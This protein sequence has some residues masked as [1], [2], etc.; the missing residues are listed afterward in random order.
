[1]KSSFI[2]LI[3]F[4]FS[5]ISTANAEVFT[6][7]EG[8]KFEVMLKPQKTLI[9]L[10]EPIFIDFDVKNLS[11]VDLGVLWGGDYRN[12]FGR[13]ESFDV[14][15]FDADSQLV[16]KP[17]TM[18]FGGLSTFQKSPVGKSYNFRLYLPHWATIESIG[19]Y[20]IQID[21]DLVVKKY[22]SK[23]MFVNMPAGIPVKLTTKINVIATNYEKMGDVID[24]I[25]NKLVEGDDTAERLAPFIND[26]RIIKYLAQAIQKN[27]WLMRYLAKFNS[28]EAL[29]AIV[30]RINDENQEVRRNVSVTLALSVHPKASVYLLKMRKDKYYAIRL[31]V[32]HYLGRLK[33]AESTELLKE[34]MYDENEINRNEANRYL[35]ERGEK[36]N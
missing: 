28:D 11:D 16:P 21:K 32:I 8:Y 12:E 27:E 34:M 26:E 15:V 29:N 2:C 10:G 3:L 24:E 20:Q 31:D 17:K 25:G 30:S 9:M 1:M 35:T 23:D 4:L 14:K 36:S 7:V 5:L 22:S 19:D 33:T 18:T 13:P 6:T